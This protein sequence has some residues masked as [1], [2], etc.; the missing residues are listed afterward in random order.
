MTQSFLLFLTSQHQHS[1]VAVEL[2]DGV[3]L[4]PY[5]VGQYTLGVA[6]LHRHLGVGSIQLIKTP[7]HRSQVSHGIFL[8]RGR[9]ECDLSIKTNKNCFDAQSKRERDQRDFYKKSTL[10]NYTQQDM[11]S[12]MHPKNL[13]L[14]LQSA[15]FP[16]AQL[17]WPRTAHRRRW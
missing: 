13:P 8:L 12:C 1:L 14:V 16:E 5:G 7:R 17:H 2:N 3:R 11:H 6:A 10:K 15:L 4:G 9:K